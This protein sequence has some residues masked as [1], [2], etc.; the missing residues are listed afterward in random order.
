MLSGDSFAPTAVVSQECSL[1]ASNS[2]HSASF[3]SPEVN[4]ESLQPTAGKSI[5]A[6]GYGSSNHKAFIFLSSLYQ[7]QVNKLFSPFF[8]SEIGSHYKILPELEVTM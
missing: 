3:V 1:E 5:K 8:L 4:I 6:I 7:M 2:P